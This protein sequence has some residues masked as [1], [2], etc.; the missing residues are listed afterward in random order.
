MLSLKNFHS[1]ASI[2]LIGCFFLNSVYANDETDKLNTQVQSILNKARLQYDL[3]AL[4]VS[5][6]L[7]G[8]NRQRDYVT[9]NYSLNNK[10]PINNHTL[11]QIG[12]IT[13]TF[14]AS[15]ILKLV[16]ENKL[17]LDDS[18]SL[19]LPQYVRWHAITIRN[20]LNHTS[21]VSNYSHGESFDKMLRANPQKYWSLLELSDL[22]YH[23]PDLARPGKKYNY[24]NTDYVLLGMVIEKVTHQSI[25]KVFDHYLEAH[26]LDHTFYAASGYP[27]KF[28]DNIAHGYNRDSTFQLNQD[29]TSVSVSSAQSAG[30]LI[31]TPND[32][33][34][35][36]RELFSG[37]IISNHSL[38]D[39]LSIIS[40]KD[41]SIIN[42]KKDLQKY[43]PKSQ[44]NE[45]GAGY[46]IGLV[47]FKQ[48][49]FTWAHAGGMLGYE[50]L[51]TF[52]PCNGIYLALAYDVKPKQQLIFTKIAREIFMVLRNSPW[53][54]H[55]V[56]TYRQG[57]V[58]PEFCY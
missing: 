20:L 45:I 21:G 47:Y 50:S 17:H 27:A 5:I 26:Q 14:T 7:P 51:Y 57:N 1:K 30:A 55:E 52:N 32:I 28:S 31:S 16:E 42:L 6:K 12:S 58:L 24:T 11:F 36:L 19:W 9:G 4:S 56:K 33:V 54:A 44:L 8:E 29:V 48:Y 43:R 23:Q 2:L 37:E 25:Q 34:K 3:P 13:K 35:W 22:A 46:G 40:E 15:I 49:G 39:M 41:A 18:V 10:T 53:V 38:D